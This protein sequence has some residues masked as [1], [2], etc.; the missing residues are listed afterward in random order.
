MAQEL[1]AVE[2]TPTIASLLTP[3]PS[4]AELECP[5][6]A[7]SGKNLGGDQLESSGPLVRSEFTSFLVPQ[8][9]AS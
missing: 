1:G 6:V 7:V 2:G 5:P 8:I 9:L 3:E 4:D